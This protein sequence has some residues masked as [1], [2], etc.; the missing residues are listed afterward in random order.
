M[1]RHTIP[2]GRVLRIP[3]ELDYPWFVMFSNAGGPLTGHPGGRAG[4]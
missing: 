2:P 1:S 3:L 4:V